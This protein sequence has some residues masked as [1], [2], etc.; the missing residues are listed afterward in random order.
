MSSEKAYYEDPANVE[1]YS[2][3]NPEH[4][5]GLLVDA[6]RPH[7]PEGATVLELGMGP[8][9]DF[10]L[11]SQRYEVTGSDFS[12]AFLQRCRVKHPQADLLLLDA[13][14]LDTDRQFDAIFS[15]KVLIHMDEEQLAQSFARQHALL[16]P[17]GIILHSFWYGDTEGQFGALTLR[18]RNEEHLERLLEEHFDILVMERHAKMSEGD[19]IYFVARA[20]QAD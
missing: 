12:T 13:L 4:D 19:S 14:T 16:N 9:K 1:G 3:F 20:R 10:E 2:K 6:L 18:R 7:L 8:G 5:G 11:L 17:G 15:N